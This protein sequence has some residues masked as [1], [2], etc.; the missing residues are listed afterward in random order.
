VYGWE[1]LQDAFAQITGLEIHGYIKAD[2]EDFK[3]LVDSFGGIPVDIQTTF[4]DTTFPN[5]T[6][7]GVVIATFTQGAEKMNGERALTFA[8]SRHGNNGEGSDLMRAKRQHLILKGML[9]AIKQPESIFWPMDVEKFYGAVTTPLKMETTLKLDDAYYLWDFYKDKD[10]YDIESFV[11]DDRYIYHPGMYPD[12]PYSAW[13]FIAKEPGFANLHSD[14]K[15]KLD[16]TY[17]DPSLQEVPESGES[18]ASLDL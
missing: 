7:T 8:R 12:S 9:E 15:A 16:R 10:L 14:I 5:N 3:W 4:T 6:D 17:Q 2:F 18:E 1:T 11:V 13:V